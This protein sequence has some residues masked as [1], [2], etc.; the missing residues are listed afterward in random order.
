[1]FEAL[2]DKLQSAFRKLTGN[3][4]LSESNINDAM[5]EVR[6][7]LLA[8]DVNMEAA[9]AFIGKVRQECLGTEVL[10]SVTPAQQAVKVVYD[11]L[12]AFMGESAAELALESP[13]GKPAVIM[14][15]GLHGSGKTTTTAKLALFIQKKYKM[16][17][18]LAACDLQRPAAI[19]QLEVLGQ[20]LS[21][22]VY[23]DRESKDVVAVAKAAVEAGRKKNC[24]VVIL[25][26]AGRLEIDATLVKELEDIRAAVSPQEILL[27]ADSALGQ[28]AV[29]VATHFDQ[30]LS[31]SGIILTKLDGDARGGAALSMRH[32][33]GKPIKFVT[34]GEQPVDLETFHPDRMASRILG[35]GD[36]LTLV[37]RAQNEFNEKEAQELEAKLRNATFGFDDFLDQLTRIQKMGGLV[38]LLKFLPGMNALPPELMDDKHTKFVQGMI[39]SMTPTERKLPE[40]IN[41]SR[42]ARIAKGCCCTPQQVTEQIRNFMNMREMMARVSRTGTAGMLNTIMGGG[43]SIANLASMMQGGALDNSLPGSSYANRGISHSEAAARQREKQ[44]RDAKRKQEKAARKKN[45]KR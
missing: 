29:S 24:Q 15:C 40:T 9:E 42:R 11:N 25:D 45:R 43:S 5:A 32:A 8:A 31:V 7:A 39:H 20:S 35:M 3:D 2:T 36:I 4:K 17:S 6:T 38:S 16:R 30:A 12:V 28:D 26:T 41:A 22:P 1:M 34:T 21:M 18:L 44:R 13:A 10:N 33:T 37:E 27:V 14:L 23:A 19:D